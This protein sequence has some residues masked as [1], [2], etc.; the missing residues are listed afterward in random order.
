M[1]LAPCF[2]PLPLPSPSPLT[3]RRFSCS[4]VTQP[5]SSSTSLSSSPVTYRPAVILPVFKLIFR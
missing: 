3:S 1:A 4:A 5:D 2:K